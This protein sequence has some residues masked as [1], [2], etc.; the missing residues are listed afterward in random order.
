MTYPVTGPFERYV[1]RSAVG[2]YVL[3]CKRTVSLRQARPYDLPLGY[4]FLDFVTTKVSQNPHYQSENTTGGLSNYS[5]L[6]VTQNQGD[7]GDVFRDEHLAATMNKARAKL[8]A[9]LSNPASMLT[10]LAESS[11]TMRMI[12]KRLRPMVTF[13]TLWRKKRYRA[14]VRSI[15]TAQ[16]FKNP[17]LERKRRKR[18][19]ILS[20]KRPADRPRTLAN[21]WIETWFGWLPTIGDVQTGVKALSRD[22]PWEYITGKSSSSYEVKAPG[23]DNSVH[24]GLTFASCGASVYVSNPNLYLASQLGLTNP[25]YTAFEL[26]PYSWL[27]AWFGN[28]EQ[29]FRQFSEFHGI[30]VDKPWYTLGL[31]DTVTFEQP[32][33]PPETKGAG[34]AISFTRNL[35]LPEVA[36]Q[37]KGI[38]RLS[39]TRGATLASLL[40]LKNPKG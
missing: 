15:L 21:A 38:N 39:A 22:F 32:L 27:L 2:P 33:W 36:L 20:E 3:S 1:Q 13:V 37:W 7:W 30:T 11:S 12:E 29:F 5:P 16:K 25:I 26:I 9:K 23:S 6:R 35:G 24:K 8:T 10:A 18:L 14:A 31:R 28:L 40:V 17:K 34:S 19:M 4:Y